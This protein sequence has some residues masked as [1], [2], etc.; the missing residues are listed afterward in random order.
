MGIG[1]IKLFQNMNERPTKRDFL[2]QNAD[3][4]NLFVTKCRQRGICLLQNADK[5]K[6]VCYKMPT[7]GYLF[8]TKCGQ[9]NNNLMQFSFNKKEPGIVNISFYL[10]KIEISVCS[11][12]VLLLDISQLFLYHNSLSDRFYIR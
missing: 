6:F 12:K 1:H 11:L 8:V 5:G 3:K 2:S 7:K 4:G 10:K 9:R